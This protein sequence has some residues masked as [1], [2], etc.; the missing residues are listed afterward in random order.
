MDNL[1]LKKRRQI[2]VAI[3][4]P[5]MYQSMYLC[6]IDYSALSAAGVSAAGA[7]GASFSVG[8]A[9]AACSVGA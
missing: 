8:N 1:V 5:F 3:I 9:G 4:S 6:R 2:A 7:A